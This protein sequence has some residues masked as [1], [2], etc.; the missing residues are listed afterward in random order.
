V[1]DDRLRVEAV[2]GMV[3]VFRLRHDRWPTRAELLALDGRGLGAGAGGTLL[4]GEV[5][6]GFFVVSLGADH[7]IGARCGRWEEEDDVW[8]S[9]APV[10]RR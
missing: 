3:E 1:F 2:G 6:G 4:V 5:G 10:A 7:A 9:D 8:W